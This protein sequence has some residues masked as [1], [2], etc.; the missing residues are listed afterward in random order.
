MPLQ[1][2]KPTISGLHQKKNGQQVEGSDPAPLVCAAETWPGILCSD[3][4]TSVEEIC[5]T[6]G[7]CPQEGHKA[8]HGME[9][10]TCVDR[11]S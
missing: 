9:Q 5:G 3:V 4:E 7:V 6:V 2:R 1:P 8:I 11:V 10:F